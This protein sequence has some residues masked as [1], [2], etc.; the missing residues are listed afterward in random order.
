M[1]SSDLVPLS[2]RIKQG[3][4]AAFGVFVAL[5]VPHA[6][7][8]TG[9]GQPLAEAANAGEHVNKTNGLCT[10]LPNENSPQ[11]VLRATRCIGYFCISQFSKISASSGWISPLSVR[12][13][14][15]A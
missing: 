2:L 6:G 13:Q 8:T 7:E 11:A 1:C 3:A 14:S 15:A 9:T 10:P 5:A 4:V 12:M